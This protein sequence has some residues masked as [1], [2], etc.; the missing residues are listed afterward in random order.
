MGKDA[1]MPAKWWPEALKYMTYVQN[2]TPMSR[3]KNRTPYELVKGTHP[4][5]RTLQVWGC[6]CFAYVPEAT[7]KDK[8]LSARAIKWRFLGIAEDTKGFRL[9]VHNNKFMVARSVTF[10]TE[11]SSGI[12]Q[13]SLG[14]DPDKLM[15]AELE[16]ID[17]LDQ[18]STTEEV[19]SEVRVSEQ[20]T[21]KLSKAVGV[22]R[23]PATTTEAV[24]VPCKS[25]RTKR[26]PV[27]ALMKPQRTRKRPERYEDYKCFQTHID[28]EIAVDQLS[29][30]VAVP[31]SLKEA[32]TGARRK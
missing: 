18:M 3:L 8:K 12:I 20:G 7:R 2:C 28:K 1:D 17:S 15:G 10:D 14:K 4:D 32:L 19:T 24:G 22:K 26:V 30:H 11:N 25:Q 31:R 29:N 27:E 23:K 16:E 13:R 6:V 21:E 5:A 9:D